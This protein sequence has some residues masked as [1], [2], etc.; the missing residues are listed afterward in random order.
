MQ[1]YNVAD[2]KT[3]LSEILDRVA[4][5]EEILLTRRGRPIARVVPAA[6]A[7]AA[8]ILGAGAHDPNINRS[9][10]ARDDWWKPLPEDET[11]PWY[12]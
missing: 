11:R 4:E 8:F 6:P 1:A 7:T 3:H 10:L 5:G 9:V 2:A 12:E